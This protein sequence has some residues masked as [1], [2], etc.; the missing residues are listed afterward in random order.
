MSFIYEPQ[1]LELWRIHFREFLC[2]QGRHLEWIVERSLKTNGLKIFATYRVDGGS[3]IN[4]TVQRIIRTRE[5]R[6]LE[7]F[8]CLAANKLALLRM[9]SLA[10]S[11]Q[12]GR[13]ITQHSLGQLLHFSCSF[14]G[15][16]ERL[17]E[18]IALQLQQIKRQ[19]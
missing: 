11:Y 7:N 2:S 18:T 10:G 6:R 16:I 1:L 12:V 9:L 5:Q 15:H 19:I 17:M 8:N 3:N 13:Y 14:V 4:H